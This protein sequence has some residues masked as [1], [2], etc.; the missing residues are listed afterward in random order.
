MIP[1][2]RTSYS[3]YTQD[4]V[5][6]INSEAFGGIIF[7]NLAYT[8]LFNTAYQIQHPTTYLPITGDLKRYDM[9]IYLYEFAWIKVTNSSNAAYNNKNIIFQKYI[10]GFYWIVALPEED[11]TY[12][13]T[14]IAITPEVTY[15][16]ASYGY[17]AYSAEDKTTSEKTLVIT[18]FLFYHSGWYPYYHFKYSIKI[19]NP[20]LFFKLTT[21]SSGYVYIF[22]A[23][24]NNQLREIGLGYGYVS[25]RKTIHRNLIKEYISLLY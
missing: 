22:T 6:M 21:D 16:Y 9:S 13:L 23:D 7:V 14:P 19:P 10:Y 12:R 15:S 25:V 1:E 2:F 18:T 20:S 11:A 24:E 4:L 17:I 8:G 3:Y 5:T